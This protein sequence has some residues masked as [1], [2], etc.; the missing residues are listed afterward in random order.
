MKRV[1]GVEKESGA[2]EVEDIA[3]DGVRSV[4][5]GNG[6]VDG[7]VVANHGV[8]MVGAG[9]GKRRPEPGVGVD[10]D[11]GDAVGGVVGA[12]S[13]RI[14]RPWGGGIDGGG[15][16]VVVVEDGAGGEYELGVGGAGGGGGGA[17]P[18]GGVGEIAVGG[19]P[20][21]GGGFGGGGD[22]EGENES[23]GDPGVHLVASMPVFLRG[24][25]RRMWVY[26]QMRSVRM[27]RFGGR[28]DTIAGF[29]RILALRPV[30]MFF[31]G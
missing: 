19:G 23:G 17:G 13:Q 10:G 26:R 4:C 25:L 3:G 12:E 28:R 30:W 29:L 27:R 7:V 6:G 2:G 9:S 8:V 5:G 15:V 11:A 21:V 14:E 31:A 18:G 20:G 1:E 24:V 22:D 16:G